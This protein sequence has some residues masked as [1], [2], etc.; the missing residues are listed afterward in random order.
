MDLEKVVELR[1]S[2]K[3]LFEVLGRSSFV[4]CKLSS[5]VIEVG[6][7]SWWEMKVM[8]LMRLKSCEVRMMKG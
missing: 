1:E 7:W 6:G 3:V 8:D 2:I 4:W 5:K